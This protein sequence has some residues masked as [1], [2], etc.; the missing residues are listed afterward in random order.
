MKKLRSYGRASLC[1]DIPPEL[2]EFKIKMI[3]SLFKEAPAEEVNPYD[4]VELVPTTTEAPIANCMRY[5][6]DGY[7][8]YMVSFRL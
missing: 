3:Y 1:P 2:Q 4:D 5:D 8:I 7:T 6:E